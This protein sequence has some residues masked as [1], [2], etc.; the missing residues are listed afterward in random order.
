MFTAL[1]I[2]VFQEYKGF[3][4]Y[5]VLDQELDTLD[6][7]SG[8]LGDGGGDT[9]HWE[10]LSVLILVGKV[11]RVRKIRYFVDSNNSIEFI[12]GRYRMWF[13][14]LKKST[15]KPYRRIELVTGLK[16]RT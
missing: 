14:I 5:L 6:R 15:T 8:S 16:E 3:V 9:T 10:Q 1:Q 2:G 12:A 11:F 4:T 13:D 7:S